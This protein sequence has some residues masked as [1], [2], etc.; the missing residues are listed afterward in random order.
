MQ[1]R[2]LRRTLSAAIVAFFVS[3]GLVSAATARL[4]SID[5]VHIDKTT[6]LRVTANGPIVWREASGLSTA[7]ALSSPL[8]LTIYGVSLANATSS[9]AQ[10]IATELGNVRLEPEAP[11]KLLLTLTAPDG[12][13]YSVRSGRSANVLEILS[14]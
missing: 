7:A 6:V 13:A 5:V 3:M 1:T 8:H 12:R 2:S 9:A 4:A 11:D 14:E 10:E